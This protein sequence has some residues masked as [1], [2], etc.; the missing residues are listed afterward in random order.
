LEALQMLIQATPPNSIIKPRFTIIKCRQSSMQNQ[1]DG[2]QKKLNPHNYHPNIPINFSFI[3]SLTEHKGLKNLSSNVQP[4][5]SPIKYKYEFMEKK[6]VR[7]K[8]SMNI[9]ELKLNL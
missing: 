9:C 3:H 7:K 8:M 1:L 6:A 5:K 4:Y 2:I